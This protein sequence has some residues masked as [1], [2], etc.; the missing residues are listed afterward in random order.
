[1]SLYQNKIDQMTRIALSLSGSDPRAYRR[2]LGEYRNM[3]VGG[4]GGP[5]LMGYRWTT[6]RQAYFGTWADGDFVE[7]LRHLGED[8]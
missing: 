4:T 6:V 8:E 1:M 3:S 7:L 5:H 2:L